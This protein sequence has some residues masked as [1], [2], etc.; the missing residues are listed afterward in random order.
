MPRARG[1]SANV[2]GDTVWTAL[3]EARPAGLSGRQ[4]ASATGMS[5]NQVAGGIRYVREHL[6]A[7]NNLALVWSRRTGYLL[8]DDPAACILFEA[9]FGLRTGGATDRMIKSVI[10][11]H[12]AV[13]GEDDAT[14]QVITDAIGS[15]HTG[16]RALA[17]LAKP[18]A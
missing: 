3:I 1:I 12:I 4:L 2:A 10:A 5:P 7:A 18:R 13:V 11:P 8:T 14:A 9:A 16:F 6:S 15:L 17:G